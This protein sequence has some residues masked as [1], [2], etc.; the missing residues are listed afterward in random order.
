[1][2]TE[3]RLFKNFVLVFWEIWSDI[4]EI[5]IVGAINSME[6]MRGGGTVETCFFPV[7]PHNFFPQESI[8]SLPPRQYYD[9]M[10]K[11]EQI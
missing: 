4:P 8:A 2:E 10:S 9:E 6:W 11:N 1:M 3:L 5:S 7:A